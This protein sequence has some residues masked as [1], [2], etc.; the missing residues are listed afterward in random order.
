MLILLLG[1]CSRLI[2]HLQRAKVLRPQMTAG[3]V[4]SVELLPLALLPV[5]GVFE[6]LDTDLLPWQ[7]LVL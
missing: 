6:L 1:H 2:L 7:I 4:S 5:V 3:Q